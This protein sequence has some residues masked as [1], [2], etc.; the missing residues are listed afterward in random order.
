MSGVDISYRIAFSSKEERVNCV[1]FCRGYRQY[2]SLDDQ[3]N[4]RGF[5]REVLDLVDEFFDL[6]L[7]VSDE[8]CLGGV[9]RKIY[10]SS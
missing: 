9:E 8:V 1:R 3:I 10:L 2:M 5:A 7:R 4:Q 6:H